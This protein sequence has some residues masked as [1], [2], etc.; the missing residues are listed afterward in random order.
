[1]APPKSQLIFYLFTSIIFF[2]NNF[3]LN[4]TKTIKTLKKIKIVISGCP[5]KLN[6]G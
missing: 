1:M 3:D 5:P 4:R 2:I 6:F